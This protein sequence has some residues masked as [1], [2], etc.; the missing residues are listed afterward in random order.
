MSRVQDLGIRIG[1][2]PSGPTAS[3]VDVPGVGVGHA[4]VVRDEPAPPQ[5]RG[6]ARTG[7]TVVDPGG[8]A[9]ARP[10]PAGAAVLNGAGECTGLLAAREWGLLESPVFLTSTMQLGRVYDAACELLLEEDEQIG[11]DVVIPVVAECDDSF[12][13]DARRMQVTRQDVAEA[14]RAARESGAATGTRRTAPPEGAV[15]A[16]TGMSCL[17]FK[18]GIGTASRVVPDGHVVGVLAMTNFGERERLTVDGVPVGRLLP[19]ARPEQKL[20]GPAGSCVVVVAT[21]G[22]LDPAGC[23]RLARRAGLGLARTGSTAHHGSGEI[24]FAFATG[25]RTARGESPAGA[26]VAGRALDPYFAAVVEATEEAVLN[27]LFQARTVTGRDGHTMEALPVERTL[28]LLRAAG[29]PA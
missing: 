13:N 29:R 14:L 22:P 27:S 15:G 4:T 16:G 7:V 11:E 2:L 25:L 21:D 9:P 18:G 24:F 10:V 8:S 1:L 20:P 28:G 12:L 3:I 5:G 23:E 6:V 17:G 26:P 19:P